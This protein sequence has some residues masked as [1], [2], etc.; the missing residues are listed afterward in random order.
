MHVLGNEIKC[1]MKINI[2]FDCKIKLPVYIY[3]ICKRL[4]KRINLVQF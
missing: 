3:I 2:A 4:E 1:T